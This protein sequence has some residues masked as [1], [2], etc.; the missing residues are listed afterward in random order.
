M[1]NPKAGH[2]DN[3]PADELR[4]LLKRAGYRVDYQ[5]TRKQG[6]ADALDDPGELVV[7]AGGD[8]TVREVATRLAGRGVPIAIL[9]LGTANNIATALSIRGRIDE[10]VA[11]WKSARRCRFDVGVIRGPWGETRFLEG[12]GFGAFPQ[13]MALLEAREPIAEPDDRWEE[14]SRDVQFLEMTLDG[15]KPRRWRLTVDGEAMVGEY[16]MLE[17]MN[18]CHVGPNL[19]LAPNASP[20]DGR[21]DIVPIGEDARPELMRYL[22]ARREERSVRAEL[23]VLSGRR[24]QVRWDGSPLHVDDEIYAD[25]PLGAGPGTAA[26]P[27]AACLDIWLDSEVEILVGA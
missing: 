16:L 26:P 15:C 17:I 24:V 6:F 27:G 4:R 3:P 21:L 23:P 11:G 9:P 7:V 5:S 19:C 25:V 8:G 14:L 18:I 10:L 20:S 2:G 22:R 1:H 12:V 13:C